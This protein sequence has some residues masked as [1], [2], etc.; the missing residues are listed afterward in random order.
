MEKYVFSKA[1]VSDR[2]EKFILVQ[3]Y[4][5]RREEPY[6]SNQKILAG[7]G[8][9]A[10]PLYVLLKPDGSFIAKSGY[11]PKYQADPATFAEFLDQALGG[12]QAS[13]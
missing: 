13:L 1:V 5:D 2:F 7:Y 9:I 4:T 8:T 12:A 3:L 6:I 11:L 10:N